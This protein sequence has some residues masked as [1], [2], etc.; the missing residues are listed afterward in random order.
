MY[1]L[2]QFLTHILD[3]ISLSAFAMWD[4][5]RLNKRNQAICERDGIDEKHREDFKDVGND[6]PLFRYE[7]F[8][9]MC[10]KAYN[11]HGL[12]QLHP[13]MELY[14]RYEISPCMLTF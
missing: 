4:Y 10:T 7:F 13:L 6:S 2:I 14:D 1:D 3:R 5:N 9:L 11:A 12:F 8:R